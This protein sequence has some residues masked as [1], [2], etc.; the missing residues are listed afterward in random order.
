MPGRLHEELAKWLTDPATPDGAERVIQPD[1]IVR[2]NIWRDFGALA[3]RAKVKA[4]SK[5]LHSLRKSCIT[6]WA[7]NHPIHVVQQWAGHASIETTRKYYLQVDDEHYER[8]AARRDP[9]DRTQL[10]TQLGQNSSGDDTV[11]LPR[12][13]AT[14]DGGRGQE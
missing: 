12:V 2:Q 14:A 3:R 13:D 8:A 1:A 4:Y 10:R 5:P 9:A 7:E 6:D 11:E